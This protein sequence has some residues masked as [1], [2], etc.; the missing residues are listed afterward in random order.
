MNDRDRLIE[1]I[2]QAEGLKNNDFPSV[3]EIA[4]HLLANGVIVPPCKVGDM[5]YV[6]WTFDGQQG[7]GF[8]EVEEIKIYD[9]K[10][11][12]MFFIDLQSDIEEFNQEYGGW[13][14]GKSI[15]DTVF[16]TKEK[17]EAHLPQPP[18]EIV[19]CKDCEHLMFS[20][21]YGECAKGHKGIVNPNDTCEHA[22]RKPPKGE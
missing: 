11:H 19:Y 6:P 18:K 16:L 14:L 20:D 17:A 1:L 3:E 8:A 7:V 13:K 10:N 12:I 21:C 4:D 9:N 5:V 22:T 2:E 15:G